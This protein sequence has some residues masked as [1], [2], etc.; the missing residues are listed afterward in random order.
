[1]AKTFPLN[2]PS[3]QSGLKV[4]SLQCSHCGTSVDGM[5]PLPPLAS[6][7]AT[8]QLFALNFIKYSGSI[9]EMAKHLN[10]SY[11]TVRNMLDDIIERVKTIEESYNKTEEN[12]NNPV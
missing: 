10:L 12:E 9:K 5:F 6:L 4:K 7:S 2:C 1:M 8:D 11:P 3:C